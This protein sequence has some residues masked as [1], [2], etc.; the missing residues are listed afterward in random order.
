MVTQGENAHAR[1]EMVTQGENMVTQD[2]CEVRMP[3]RWTQGENTHTKWE[4]IT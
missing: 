2:K 3:M 4:M 1:W